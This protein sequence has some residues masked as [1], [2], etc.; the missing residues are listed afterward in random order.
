M[1]TLLNAFMTERLILWR[2]GVSSGDVDPF[3]LPQEV[4][5]ARTAIFAAA[6]VALSFLA[7]PVTHSKQPSCQYLS[8]RGV[9]EPFQIAGKVPS[10]GT[11]TGKTGGGYPYVRTAANPQPVKGDPGWCQIS[12]FKQYNPGLKKTR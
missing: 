4:S 1:Y 5:M 10:K 3:F 7:S 2:S 9:G 11:C 8:T 6:V 12:G